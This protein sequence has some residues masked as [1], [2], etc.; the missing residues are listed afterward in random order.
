[1]DRRADD[2]VLLEHAHGLS[3]RGELAR[4]DEPRRPATDDDHVTINRPCSI[5][6][7]GHQVLRPRDSHVPRKLIQNDSRIKRQSSDIDC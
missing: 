7:I 6:A 2:V 4:G 1:M 5:A 3:R